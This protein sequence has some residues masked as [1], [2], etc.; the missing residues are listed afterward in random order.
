M[1]PAEERAVRFILRTLWTLFALIVAFAVLKEIGWI[2]QPMPAPIDT[3][4][5]TPSG[6][7]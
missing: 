4:G 3:G 1:S 5:Q 7:E 6:N 2:E